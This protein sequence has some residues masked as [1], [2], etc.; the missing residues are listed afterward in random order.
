[1]AISDNRSCSCG[2][3]T[4]QKPVLSEGFVNYLQV[5]SNNYREIMNLKMRG[6]NYSFASR[7][8]WPE[9]VSILANINEPEDTR[10][11]G[12]EDTNKHTWT[13][14]YEDVRIKG[15]KQAY[16]NL[17]GYEDARMRGY[18]QVRTNMRIWGCEGAR[19]QISR[20]EPKHMRVWGCKDINKSN[21]SN[22]YVTS[23][24]DTSLYT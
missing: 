10:I 17:R 12:C 24:L 4:K 16:M 2:K 18:R 7:T 9:D 1:M 3:S 23:R 11:W 22:M 5:E 15:Y 14:G 8:H 20:Q 19:I 21:I 13:W 6:Y